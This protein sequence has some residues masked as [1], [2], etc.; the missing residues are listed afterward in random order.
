MGA[1][2]AESVEARGLKAAA[3]ACAAVSSSASFLK[4]D[5]GLSGVKDSFSVEPIKG[6]LFSSL[7]SSFVSSFS[8]S[9]AGLNALGAAAGLK[10][11]ALLSRFAAPIGL[12]GLEET[13]A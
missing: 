2:F 7:I 9:D 4:A 13:A 1:A 5:R 10:E 11:D 3:A 6:A 8:G 12:K